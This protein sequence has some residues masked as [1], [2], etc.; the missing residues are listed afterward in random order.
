MLRERRGSQCQI[1]KTSSYINRMNRQLTR[2]EVSQHNKPDD[3]WIIIGEKVYDVTRF[4]AEH[5]G[6]K[7]VLL[8]VAGKD[9]TQQF[10]SLHKPE[11]LKKYGA[12]LLIGEIADLRAKNNTLPSLNKQAIVPP[13]SHTPTVTVLPPSL[14]GEQ[15]PFGDPVWYQDWYSP[16]YNESHRRFR[17]AMREWVEREVM[18]FCHEWDEAKQ[19][20]SGLR[21]KAFE[22][23][24]L[25]AVVGGR[26]PTEYV[27]DRIAGGVRPEE[28]DAFHELIL[29]DELSRCASGGVVSAMIT[30]LAVGL[31][32]VLNFGSQYLKDKIVRDCLRGEK[33]ICLCITEPYAGSDVANLKT[34]AKKTPDGRYY[35]VNGE[36]KW[37]TNGIFADYFTVAA[38]TGGPGMNGISLLLIERTMPGVSCRPMNCQGVWCAGT[39]YVTFEDV[40]VPVENLIGK[41]NLGFR[42]VMDNFNHERWGLTVQVVRFARVCLEE[43]IKYAH[44]RKTF[45][46]RLID[47][48]V[49]RNKIAHM[50]RNVEATQAW[51]DLITYQKTKL[52]HKEQSERL[53]GAIALLK[54][55][56]TTTFE[57]C[58]REASQIFGGLAYT[59]G[60]Q[61]EKVERL[62]REV[63]GFAIPGGSE[64][65]MLDL[66]VRMAMKRAKL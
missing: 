10:E 4:L 44:K 38:R 54:A 1:T 39:T 24:W 33:A 5:P 13:Q 61:G 23:G 43:A 21:R 14:F 12:P 22:A 60:G 6:G 35:I 45:G 19:V 7:K 15:V 17:V 37:I 40:K 50:A 3:C 25:P 42:Y 11:T 46:Q 64:E 63:R 56:A 41:E 52:S 16:Y 2:E 65:I 20:P 28:W 48:P 27:G 31:P 49:L 51:L 53:G 57:L 62:Y 32:P 26:W 58:A 66:G 9:A 18:P 36:K 47:H 29:V 59:R 55:Q 8:N 34:E 30:G